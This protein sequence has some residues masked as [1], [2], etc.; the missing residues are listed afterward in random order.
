[1]ATRM[2]RPKGLTYKVYKSRCEA[3]SLRPLSKSAFESLPEA[4]E[5]DD[6]E[7]DEDEEE[8][9]EEEEE[10][11]EKSV[12]VDPD[13][14]EKALADYESVEEGLALTG[15]TGDRETY[16]QARLD[17]GTI[18]KSERTELGRIWSGVA[19]DDDEPLHKSL[20]EVVR[21]DDED[22]GDLLDASPFLKS[23]VDGL[24][25]RMHGLE[26]EVRGSS[27]ANLELVKA[28]GGLIKALVKSHGRQARI[29]DV[30]ESRLGIVEKSPAPR[31]SVGSDPRDVRNR[32][33][34]KSRVGGDAGDDDK[35]KKSQVFQ[36][37]RGLM[38]KADK[39]ND[40]RGRDAIAHATAKFESSGQISR[41][42]L[43]RVQ[44]ELT[45]QSSNQ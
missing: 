23:M 40:E 31:R 8:E 19:E 37:L 7:E 13:A 36:G 22:N 27:A 5:E 21:D 34:G 42:L 20:S 1:M 24:E 28:Q 4:K 16:L 26:G 15:D 43:N 35:L 41:N 11:S 32:E 44:E 33:I 39:A 17:A 38:L 3:D 6:E 29:I 12:S 10:E 14:L 30:L 18:S 45:E 9:E 2:M 25:H